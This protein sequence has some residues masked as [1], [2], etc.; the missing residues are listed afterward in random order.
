MNF[1]TILNLISTIHI[2]ARTAQFIIVAIVIV[3]ACN[4]AWRTWQ[5]LSGK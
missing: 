3:L 1:N 2:E 4:Q 5:T